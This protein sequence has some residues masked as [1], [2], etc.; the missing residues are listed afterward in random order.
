MLMACY[1]ANMVWVPANWE[2][3]HELLKRI[4]KE[5]MTDSADAKQGPAA[6]I[7][8]HQGASIRGADVTVPEGIT[9]I[10]KR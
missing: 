1:P 9:V 2:Q 6:E 8:V 5:L 3:L 4:K 7:S 10:G